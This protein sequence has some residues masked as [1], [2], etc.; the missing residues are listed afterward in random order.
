MCPDISMC[1]WEWC[2][3]KSICYR[4]MAK[5]NKYIQSRSKFEPKNCTSFLP[6]YDLRTPKLSDRD[7]ESVNWDTPEV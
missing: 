2:D 4:H 7:I 1:S 3:K 5:P 6:I